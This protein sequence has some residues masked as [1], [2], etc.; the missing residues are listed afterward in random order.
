MGGGKPVRLLVDTRA[1][2]SVATQLVAPTIEQ[3]DHIQGATGETWTYSVSPDWFS[4]D[5][6]WLGTCFC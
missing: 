1:E 6:S 2:T 4:W 3:K 5:D